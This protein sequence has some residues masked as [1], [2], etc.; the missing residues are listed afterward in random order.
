MSVI[1]DL[2]ALQELDGIIREL[3]QQANDIP[4]RRQQELD[5]I[6]LERDD[7]TRAEEA[8]QVLKDEV[9]RGESYIAE[10]KETI[11]KFKLQ[12]PSLKTQAALDAMQS[13][14]SKTENDF[15]DAE[16][17]AIE[18]HLKIEPAEQYA[19]ECKAR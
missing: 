3:E 18:T 12:I 6:K 14:I 19:N 5:K 17:S 9:A 16:L 7:F 2:K 13:Q 1:D 4:I 15:K 10:L 11:H 8:V